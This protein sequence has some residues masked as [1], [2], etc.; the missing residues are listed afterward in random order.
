[1]SFHTITDEDYNKKQ[2]MQTPQEKEQAVIY[3]ER[4]YTTA[5]PPERLKLDFNP[6]RPLMSQMEMQEQM[7][8][9]ANGY[10]VAPDD[11]SAVRVIGQYGWLIRSP[12]DCKIRRAPKGFTWQSPPI[13]PEE[14]ALG[15][16]T[17]SGMYVD[18]LF[19]S[20]YPKFC[21]GLRFYYPKHL[22]MMMKDL[23]NPFYHNPDRTFRVWEGIK[24]HE[25]TR[26][27]NAYAFLP[28]YHVFATNFL[29]QLLK[30]TVIKRGDPIGVIIPVLLPKQFTLE[31]LQYPPGWR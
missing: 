26:T 11:C 21:C 8:L 24:T 28:D 31:E 16:N 13:R 22:A 5:L 3:W 20:D 29:L 23:P 19:N 15:F 12:A 2:I 14:R 17:F 1:M 4:E 10:K 7:S 25:Y 30:P 6:H 9:A 18:G 27:E